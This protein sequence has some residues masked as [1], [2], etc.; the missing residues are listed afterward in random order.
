[1]DRGMMALR[2]DS[3]DMPPN[4]PHDTSTAGDRAARREPASRAQ[5]YS[6][7]L[8]G[9]DAVKKPKK[10]SINGSPEEIRLIESRFRRVSLDSD[11]SGIRTHA[12]E[13]QCKRSQQM[14]QCDGDR[15]LRQIPK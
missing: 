10:K 12:R 7:Q 13:D 1:M 6:P 3:V 8:A 9:A 11:H 15:I 14:A 4:A 5:I 2:Y